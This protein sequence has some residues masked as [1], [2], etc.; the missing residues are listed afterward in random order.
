[1]KNKQ[2]NDYKKTKNKKYCS[3]NVMLDS[4][5]CRSVG[6]GGT[7]VSFYA[8]EKGIE[9]I[10][11]NESCPFDISTRSERDERNAM[12]NGENVSIILWEDF[13]K[14]AEGMPKK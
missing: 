6:S 8:T 14:W 11:E 7:S 10:W 3:S 12:L 4:I 5:F 2:F 1:M 9:C 13:L